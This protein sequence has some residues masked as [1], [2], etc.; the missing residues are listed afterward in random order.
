[1]FVELYILCETFHCLPQPGALFE[2]DSYIMY[3]L[4]G[5][6]KAFK[7]KEA[8]DIRNSPMSAQLQQMMSRSGVR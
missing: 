5:A 6:V 1:M 2:Q 4:L 8:Q 3:G 7:E